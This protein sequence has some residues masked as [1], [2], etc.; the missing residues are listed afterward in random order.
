M[1]WDLYDEIAKRGVSVDT[2]SDII[3]EN[4]YICPTDEMLSQPL[5]EGKTI[6]FVY[7]ETSKAACTKGSGNRVHVRW[8]LAPLGALVEKDRWKLWGSD[9]LVFSYSS[10]VASIPDLPVSNILQIVSSP[11]PGDSTD[12]SKKD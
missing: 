9:E 7:P 3:P 5:N 11:T 2:Q 4:D 10:A 12:V 8:L 1:L 6:V